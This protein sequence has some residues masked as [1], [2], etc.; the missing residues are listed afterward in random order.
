[1]RTWV[2]PL[3]LTLAVLALAAPSLR[4]E[5]EPAS[6]AEMLDVKISSAAK[7]E[8]TVRNAPAAVTII[9]ER[10][11]RQFGYTTLAEVLD[12]VRGFYT[13]Y[14][15]NYGYL[16]AR[17]F[18]RPADYN[19]RILLL[20]NGHP[21]NDNFYDG[22]DIRSTFALN[23][24]AIERIEIVRGPGSTLYG[25]G[26]MF[27]VINVV[28]KTGDAL[29]GGSAR[30]EGGSLGRRSAALVY[31]GIFGGA[32]LAVS[33]TWGSIAGED[34]YFPEYDSPETQGGVARGLDG[35]EFTGGHFRLAWKGLDLQAMYTWRD[36]EIPTASY[37]A[38]FVPVVNP[39]TRDQT[40]FVDA[41]R[42]WQ[43]S[44]AL[45]LSARGFVHDYYYTGRYSYAAAAYV[46]ENDGRWSGAESQV[47]WD[48]NAANRLVVGA[49]YT[50]HATARY[51]AG[52]AGEPTAT[53]LDR[54]YHVL[55][56]FAQDAFQW[57]PN[58]ALTAGVR[59]DDYSTF[60]GFASPR[61]ALVYHRGEK[62]SFK[63]LWG[64]AFR[65]PNH[66][67]A[68]Y[69]DSSRLPN[70][71][72]DPEEIVTSELLVERQIGDAFIGSVSVY[73][74]TMNNLISAVPVGSEG[75]VQ[76]R[77]LDH[78]AAQG[79][80][81]QLDANLAGGT[82]GYLSWAHQ[83]TVDDATDRQLTNSPKDIFRLGLAVPFAERFAA[84]AEA[85]YESS[86]TTVYE[87]EL[88]SFVVADLHLTAELSERIHLGL[89]VRNAFDEDYQTPGGIEHVQAGLPQ[90]GRDARLRLTFDF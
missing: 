81:L 16:G 88:G 30:A 90:E 77:N 52:F 57:T 83:E 51:L 11:I 67:E 60:G 24:D 39:R 4:A 5:E 19:S 46:D 36:K 66:F 48:P 35:E 43:L 32:D 64:R 61:L 21:F 75:M 18:G 72:L 53:D 47:T 71:A 69:T 3:A 9:T 55:S 26:A 76:F 7:Y 22:F 2:P 84:A 10:E 89:H 59:Y 74:Y 13:S 86:R 28:T 70:P 42:T 15:R 80:E 1:M 38:D 45:T 34:L 65:R 29:A 56:V 31:G 62:T 79:V 6:L 41:T 23:L 58:L 68:F 27:G 12:H 20:V 17:G 50:G 49:A 85:R 8:Q 73:R 33:G 54:P 14:D 40:V 44:P 63:L 82:W 37:A 78:V 87:T 25:S